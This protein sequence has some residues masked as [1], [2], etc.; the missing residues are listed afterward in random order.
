[1]A[2]A[3]VVCNALISAGLPSFTGEYADWTQTLIYL[4]EMTFTIALT[5]GTV[6]GAQNLT[7][8]ALGL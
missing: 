2:L 6:K 3:I 1:M 8:R 7:S 5:V 4:C